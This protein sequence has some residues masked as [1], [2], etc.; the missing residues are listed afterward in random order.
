MAQSLALF[1]HATRDD[2]R[3]FLERALRVGEAEVRL[4]SRDTVLAVYG[5]VQ[6]A[7]GLLDQTPVVLVMRA[8]QLR[9]APEVPV[10]AT[11]QARSLLDRI[12]RMG[13]IGLDLE[14]PEVRT[15][16]A[17]AGVLPP[18]AG[19]QPLGALDVASL[20]QVATEGI[21]RVA[22]ALPQNPGEA[23]ARTVRNSVWSIPIAPGVP[24]IAAFAAESMGFTGADQ[25][26][27]LSQTQTWLRIS[28]S[29]GHVLIRRGLRESELE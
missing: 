10:D 11:V 8:V 19:W 21:Q 3:V 1:D 4:V 14:V 2:L 5:C 27:S 18:I 25:T 20:Q 6:T 17:W 12:A 16:A 9:A 28:T 15:N 23:V 22:A 7:A 26:A 24:A 13:I 29:R